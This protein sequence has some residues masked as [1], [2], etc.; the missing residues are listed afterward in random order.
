[1]E[2]VNLTPH[3]I[4]LRGKDGDVTV[5]PSGQ[6]ARVATT[7]TVVAE[8]NGFPV[9]RTVQG[10]PQ[11]IPSPEDGKVFIASTLVASVVRRADVLSPDTGPTAIRE[12]GSWAGD[13][14][15]SF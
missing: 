15:A 10:E 14:V 1:M 11:G 8:V 2:F 6:V 9:V 5:A 12:N 4:V 7:Q 3:S 13:Q